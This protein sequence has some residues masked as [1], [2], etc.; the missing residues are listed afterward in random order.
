M[1]RA[2]LLLASL[3]LS[4]AARSDCPAAAAVRELAPPAA[5]QAAALQLVDCLREADPEQRDGLG[6]E[7]LSAWMRAD[8]LEVATLQS[9]RERLLGLLDAAPDALGVQQPFAVLT[10]SEVARVDRLK[11]FLTPAQRAELV[12][13]GSAWL[14]GWRDYRGFD[15]RE[16]WRHGVAHAADLLLQLVLNPALTDAQARRILD[17]LG[18]QVLADSAHSYRFGEG[19]R[20]ARAAQA[21]LARSTLDAARWTAWLDRLLQPL[22]EAKAL[23]LHALT[24][25]HNL[26]EFLWP[27]YVG[28][29]EQPDAALRERLL[30]GL[31]KALKRLP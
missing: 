30:P 23:D 16:G 22:A 6:F 21:A 25:L 1:R 26:R 28:I 5:V 7:Q 24:Q 19:A 3:L 18:S 13:R 4:G 20:L 29:N 8:R 12:E 17:A 11:P 9:L 31:A 2:A 10:L 27:L 15:A 14:Q